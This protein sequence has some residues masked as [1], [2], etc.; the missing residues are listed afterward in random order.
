MWYKDHV[1]YVGMFAFYASGGEAVRD[2]LGAKYCRDEPKTRREWYT[3]ATW[4]HNCCITF[5]SGANMGLWV[6]S[7]A[8]WVHENEHMSIFNRL[9]TV[10]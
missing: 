7:E 2:R 5:V 9:C 3:G 8:I 1:A 4:L 6:R 10:A